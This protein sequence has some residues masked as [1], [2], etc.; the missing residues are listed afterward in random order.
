MAL[1][2]LK[3]EGPQLLSR[4]KEPV[5]PYIL[6]ASELIRVAGQLHVVML[7]GPTF[8]SC[9]CFFLKL[10]DMLG[11]MPYSVSCHHLSSL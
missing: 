9:M 4:R 2:F 1:A 5:A 3:D 6:A 11:T 8:L 10:A 7:A